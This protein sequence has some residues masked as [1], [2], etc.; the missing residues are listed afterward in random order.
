MFEEI[1][2]V[3]IQVV[4]ALCMLFI[5]YKLVPYLKSKTDQNTANLIAQGALIAAEAVEKLT[6]V[7]GWNSDEKRSNAIKF[8]TKWL[9]QR[10]ITVSEDELST[11]IE[12]AVLK[13]DQGFNTTIEQIQCEDDIVI[14]DEEFQELL[15]SVLVNGGKDLSLTVLQG[16]I[17]ALGGEPS[18]DKDEA[19]QQLKELGGIE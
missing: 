16:L 13:I 14:T 17:K 4:G 12:S 8:A 11:V 15:K 2:T 10:G 3:V 6:A 19:V 1:M 5:T 7:M 18:D 9:S